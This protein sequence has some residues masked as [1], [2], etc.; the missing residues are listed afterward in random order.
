MKILKF[1]GTVLKNLFSKPATTLYPAAPAHFEERTRGHVQID[2]GSCIF[3]GLC[4]RKCPTGAI[5]VKKE[6]KSWAIERFNCI[7]CGACVD[8][9]PKKCLAMKNEYTEPD[10]KK[11]KDVFTDA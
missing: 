11:T 9:C 2:I 4:S 10:T 5:E 8:C 7:Q 1:S 3:C 6:G